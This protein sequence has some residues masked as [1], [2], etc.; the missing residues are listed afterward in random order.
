M[1]DTLQFFARDP[2]HRSHH[3]DE[4]TFRSRVRLLRELRAAALPRRG[5]LRQGVAPG[6]DAR[7]TSGSAG[8]T[9]G[10]CSAT[11]TPSRARSCSSWA[12]NWR[13]PTSGTTTGASPGRSRT[14]RGM[15]GR[16]VALRPQR[17]VQGAAGAA[18]PRL[19]P[20]GVRVGPRR[21][22]AER[23][24][25]LLAD[26]RRPRG[27]SPRRLQLHA[28]G[29]RGLPDRRALAGSW[30]RTAERRPEERTAGAGRATRRGC[31][32]IRSRRTAAR[33]PGPADP[34]AGVRLPG[35]RR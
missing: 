14:R 9:T 10:C 11:C 35:R 17:G 32:R 31:S 8:R 34:A 22:C 12:R 2:I 1:H 23:S 28:R 25:E 29:A 7:E 3:Q 16:R 24:H 13:S 26:R 21:R 20:G 5:G 33:S 15:R 6:E 19:R 18:P 30:S 27:P 4:L